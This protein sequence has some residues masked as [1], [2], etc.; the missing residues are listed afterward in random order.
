MTNREDL[1]RA[2]QQAKAQLESIREMVAALEVDYDRLEELREMREE[3][4]EGVQN[5]CEEF[6]DADMEQSAGRRDLEDFDPDALGVACDQLQE[7]EEELYQFGREYGE[8][9][10]DLEAAAGDCESREDAEQRI[11]ED[12][13]SI[14]VRS[15]WGSPGE[16]MEAC[17][18]EILLC[19]GGPAVR[20]RGE[21]NQYNEPDRAWLEYQDWFTPWVEY[22][23]EGARDVLVE[24]ASQFYFGE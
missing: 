3:L 6:D 5:A 9:L 7:A 12:P 10:A 11:Q 2:E 18:F 19:T 17:E 16:K 23:E 1:E 24:Y 20:I 8:E 13:L 22:Y 14:Q 15:C 4:Q 21:L